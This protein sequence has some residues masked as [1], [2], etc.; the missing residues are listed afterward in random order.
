MATTSTVKTK[1]IYG[2]LLDIRLDFL[3]ESIKKTGI[4]PHAQFQYFELEDII[5][6]ATDTM[7]KHNCIYLISF[8]TVG[9]RAVGTLV[10]VENNENRIEFEIPFVMIAEPSKFRMNE[11]QGV[12]A[13]VTYYRRYL[14]MTMLDLV[15]HDAFD[16]K[17]VNTEGEISDAPTPPA[18]KKPATPKEREAIK[19][20]LTSGGE[21]DNFIK[22]QIGKLLDK[23]VALDP[24]QE[25]FKQQVMTS[26]NGLANI[27]KEN[28]EALLD[29]LRGAIEQYEVTS[30]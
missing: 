16:D 28:A 15:E 24:A 1:S 7:A 30:K 5:P 18:P 11:T 17:K 20:N 21:V 25:E 8:D 26:T 22:D 23:L 29:G 19:E 10:D 13:A 12:G 4:N 27:S 6:I 2:K 14:Y 3:K 9:S